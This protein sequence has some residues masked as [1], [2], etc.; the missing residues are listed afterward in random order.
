MG[1]TVKPEGWLAGARLM[2]RW[3]CLQTP[4]HLCGPAQ[5]QQ[6]PSLAGK[7]VLSETELGDACTPHD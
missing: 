2:G 3:T 1:I 5:L 6:H 7:Q 4:A